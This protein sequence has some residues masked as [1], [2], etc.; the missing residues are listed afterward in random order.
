MRHKILIL[1][2]KG[3]VG[4]STV[5]SHL[6]RCLA[7]KDEEKSIGL[8]DIDICGPSIPRVMGLEGEQVGVDFFVMNGGSSSICFYVW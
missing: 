5:T 3:G 6:A 4:K 1:S 7:A 8:L 2:G